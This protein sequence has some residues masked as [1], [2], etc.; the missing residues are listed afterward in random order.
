MTS[1]FTAYN[2]THQHQ[3]LLLLF[4]RYVVSAQPFGEATF[5][6]L[7]GEIGDSVGSIGKDIL[8]KL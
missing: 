7:V 6:E 5:P 1:L 3:T 4:A 8:G 2:V